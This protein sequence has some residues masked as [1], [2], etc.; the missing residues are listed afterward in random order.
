MIEYPLKHSEAEIQ[1][2]LWYFLRKRKI[3]ARLQ[4]SASNLQRRFLFDLVVFRDEIAVCIVE[5]K[6]WS[7]RYAKLRS[8]QHHRNTKQ[9]ISYKKAFNLPV[10]TIGR[11]SQVT[12]TITEIEK[13]LKIIEKG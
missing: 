13:L 9:I 8:Y 4:V 7:S 5:C 10:L 11:M 2:L 3:E 1:A 6:S 12:N